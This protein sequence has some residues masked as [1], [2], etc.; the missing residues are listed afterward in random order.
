MQ[1]RYFLIVYEPDHSEKD[2]PF[3]VL[4]RF[5]RLPDDLGPYLKTAQDAA[6]S[7]LKPGQ[8]TTVELYDRQENK[9]IAKRQ[10]YDPYRK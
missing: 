2:R 10:I 5:D 4:E 3:V 1:D 9:T 6:E 7:I 8:E